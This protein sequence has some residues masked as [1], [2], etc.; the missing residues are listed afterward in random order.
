MKNIIKSF[1]NTN[2]TPEDEMQ[3]EIKNAISQQDKIL[4]F[5]K[6]NKDKKYTPQ[7]ILEILFK[8]TP[9]TSV[10]R[11]ITNL[12]TEGLLIKTEVTRKGIYGKN[13]YC[14]KYKN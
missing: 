10:R 7:E 4:N 6:I 1:F 5:F 8:N 2:N 3:G 11:A 9:I 13:N 14:W 12:T